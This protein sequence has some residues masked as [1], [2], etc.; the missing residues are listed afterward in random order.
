MCLG[1][2]RLA[3]AELRVCFAEE[4]IEIGFGGSSMRS[5]RAGGWITRA[6][7]GWRQG[8]GEGNHVMGSDHMTSIEDEEE[9]SI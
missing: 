5:N 2:V 6:V 4:L 7:I 9:T 8:G 3:R 1:L